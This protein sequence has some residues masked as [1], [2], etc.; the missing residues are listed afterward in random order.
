MLTAFI[1][2][3]LIVSQI[4]FVYVMTSS[5]MRIMKYDHNDKAGL[6]FDVCLY[7]SGYVLT[8]YNVTVFQ[9]VIS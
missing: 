8:I 2:C 3:V 6:A 5:M 7:L 9:M 1:V 4:G